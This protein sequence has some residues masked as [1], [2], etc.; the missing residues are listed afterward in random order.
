AGA[1]YV[2]SAFPFLDG[3]EITLAVLLIVLLAAVNLRG[4]RE[5]GLYFAI[6]TYAFMFSILGMCAYGLWRLFQ[7]TLPQVESAGLEI[8]KAP[9]YEGELTMVTLVLLLAR[10]FSSGCA[11]LTGVEAI[12]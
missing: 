9:G 1:H 10:A 2:S 5:S 6:P 7:G 4:V 8:V 3:Q 11:A 12:S